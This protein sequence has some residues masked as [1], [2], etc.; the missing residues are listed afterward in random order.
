MPPGATPVPPKSPGGVGSQGPTDDEPWNTEGFRLFK[1]LA[2]AS[3]LI[4]LLWAILALLALYLKSR[5]EQRRRQ[6]ELEGN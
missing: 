2:V 4:S 5:F 3:Y 6:L 1:F